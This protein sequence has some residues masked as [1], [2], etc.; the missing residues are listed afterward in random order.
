L[1]SITCTGT[2][3]RSKPSSS[4]ALML[5]LGLLKSG[6]PVLKSGVSV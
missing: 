2:E 1:P 3:S 4:R 5:T 6:W